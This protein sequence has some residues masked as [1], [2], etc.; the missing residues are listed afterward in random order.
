VAIA[1]GDQ[2]R[3][4]LSWRAVLPGNVRDIVVSR[5]DDHGATWSDPVRVHDDGWV[6]EGCPHAGPSML[7]D[8]AGTL[9]VGWWT[10]REGAAGTFYARS[11]DGGRAFT[12]RV[13][14][15]EA[16]FSRPA[17]VQLAL[18][19]VGMVL[20]AWDDGRDSLPRVLLRVSRD[21]GATFGD[22]IPA[23]DPVIAA[24]F[25]VVALREG[26]VTVAWSQRTAESHAHAEHS[27]PDMSK[28]S[29]V[30]PLPEVGAQQVLVRHG[31][32]AR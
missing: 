10:G 3:M 5:S 20:A 21:G 32:I 9:H 4:Y 14:L 15:G 30:M 29:S 25:P 13:A 19:G 8:A 31:R 18:D 23:S 26:T 27:R 12:P 28:P 11:T 16:A 2:G 17:H 22:E 1:T 6:F 7:V 24:S